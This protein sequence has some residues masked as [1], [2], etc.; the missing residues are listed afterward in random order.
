MYYNEENREL[1][2]PVSYETVKDNLQDIVDSRMFDS[3]ENEKES[4]PEPLL[5]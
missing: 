4:E 5:I 3:F 1:Y 2:Q